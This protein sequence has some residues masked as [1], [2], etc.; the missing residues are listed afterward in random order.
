[1][2]DANTTGAS[3]DLNKDDKQPAALKKKS[4]SNR[5]LHRLRN[6][7]AA[8]ASVPAI[9]AV[10][11]GLTGYWSAWKIVSNDFLKIKTPSQT[12]CRS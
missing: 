1:M 7:G 10:I 5:L 2:S 4:R 6:V 11:G 12:A 9:G 3:A 8:I